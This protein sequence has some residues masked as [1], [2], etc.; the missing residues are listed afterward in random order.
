MIKR[1]LAKKLKQATREYPVVALV[2]PRQSGKTTLV[3]QV[4]AGYKYVSLEDLDIRTFAQTDPRGFLETYS[5]KVIFDEAQR[6]PELFSYI[7]GII[8]ENKQQGQFILTGSQNFLLQENITQSLAGRVSILTLLPFSLSEI[9]KGGFKLDD[10]NKYLFKGLYP[11]LYDKKISERE[12]YLNYIQTYIERDVRQI[13]QITDLNTFQRFVKLCAGRT[14]QLLNL[15]ALANDTGITHNTAKSW[16]SVLEASFLVFLLQ[17]HHK[18]FNKR[19]V[20]TPK[21]YFYDTGLASSLLGIERADQVKTHPLRGSLFESLIV[22]EIVKS[23][24]NQGQSPNIFFWRDKIGHEID[25]LYETAGKAISVEIKSSQTITESFFANLQYW[26]K[27]SG[28]QDKDSILI[29]GGDEEQKR[30]RGRVISWKN[31][32]QVGETSKLV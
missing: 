32:G 21:L 12:W 28:G 6:V 10:Y 4:F 23:R 26:N 5:D 29:Y 7:Q 11:R 31:T 30:S 3:R 13:K 22:S 27:L 2:G 16:L 17:P 9:G 20:K 19:L 15:S 18:N 1:Q 14:G 25:C 24:L 8:D